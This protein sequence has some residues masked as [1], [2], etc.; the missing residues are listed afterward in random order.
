[1][2]APSWGNVPQIARLPAGAFSVA[3]RAAPLHSPPSPRP[4]Q[5]RMR[6]SSAGASTAHPGVVDGGSRP[7]RNVATPMV[8]SEAT[9]VPLRPIRSP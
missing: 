8:R 4:W 9:S 3:S 6:T 7:M 5:K 1:M 2:G